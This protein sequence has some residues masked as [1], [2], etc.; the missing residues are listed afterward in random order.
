MWLIVFA[1]SLLALCGICFRFF[2]V[3]LVFD[4][5]TILYGMR[6]EMVSGLSRMGRY[7]VTSFRECL[8]ELVVMEGWI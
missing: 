3:R 7:D 1:W 8:N 2:I 6:G 5:R 4:Y